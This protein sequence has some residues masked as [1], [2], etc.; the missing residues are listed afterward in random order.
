MEENKGA[1]HRMKHVR[2]WRGDPVFQVLLVL[3]QPSPSSVLST[4]HQGRAPY[5]SRNR[6]K[7]SLPKGKSHRSFSKHAALRPQ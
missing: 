3:C 1:L 4:P 5:D 7:F 6:V 2:V